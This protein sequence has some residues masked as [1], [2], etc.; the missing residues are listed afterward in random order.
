MKKN[1]SPN[2]LNPQYLF[3]KKLSVLNDLYKNL[4]RQFE[5]L[6]YG[7]G[8]GAVK[9]SFQNEKLI[10][11]LSNLDEEILKFQENSPQNSKMIYLSE[12]I[13]S[14][15]DESRSIQEKVTK[16]FENCFHS[17]KKELNEFQVKKQVQKYLQNQEFLWKSPIS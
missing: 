1:K 12:K 6:K 13:F 15:M 17:L 11:I 4:N 2:D 3:E 5:I 7:D 10:Q 9:L 14:L 16:L 8:E